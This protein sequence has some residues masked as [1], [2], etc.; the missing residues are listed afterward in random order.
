MA[1]GAALEMVVLEAQAE[2]RVDVKIE[3]DFP[4]LPY[5]VWTVAFWIAVAFFVYTYVNARSHARARLYLQGILALAGLS[6]LALRWDCL[7]AIVA[8]LPSMQQFR[9]S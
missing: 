4:F 9:L 5:F 2:E 8:V 3:F 1:L 7:L 6:V